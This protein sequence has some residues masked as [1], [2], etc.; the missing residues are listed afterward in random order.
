MKLNGSFTCAV[1]VTRFLLLGITLRKYSKSVLVNFDAYDNPR[2]KKKHF[3]F[4]RCILFYMCDFY[5]DIKNL[6]YILCMYM[7]FASIAKGNLWK[8]SRLGYFR[9]NAILLWYSSEIYMD[10]TYIYIHA[11]MHWE[12]KCHATEIQ[13]ILICSSKIMNLMVQNI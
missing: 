7:Y 3:L 12:I 8:K 11:N 6:S 13:N 2:I 9:T 10:V 1:L 4:L 5:R